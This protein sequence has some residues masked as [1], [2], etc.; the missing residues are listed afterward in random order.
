MPSSAQ[1]GTLPF[2]LNIPYELIDSGGRGP[3]PLI[4]YLHGYRQNITY[5][6]KK[7]R[8]LLRVQAYHLFVQGPYPIYD[9]QHKREVPEWG[10][11][12]YLYDGRQEQFIRSLEKSSEFL[13]R[14]LHKL[15]PKLHTSHTA[16]VGYSMGAYLAGYFA[17]SRPALIRD[18]VVMGGRIKTEHFRGNKFSELN[19]LALHGSDD[20]SVKAGPA[21][22]SC[23]ELSAMGANVEF[24][25]L[26]TAHKLNPEYVRAAEDWL[27]NRWSYKI[28]S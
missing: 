5:L 8:P 10:R 4:V 1:T 20:K 26:D 17:L 28:L 14:L 23:R 3:K 9:E 21:R 7:L 22:D 13:E 27:V 16:L 19:I 2:T 25:L 11:A 12:W 6:K 18:L 24:K 15:K